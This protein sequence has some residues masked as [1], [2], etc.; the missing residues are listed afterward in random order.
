M[1]ELGWVEGRNTEYVL[2]Y[3]GGDARRYEPVIAELLAQRPDVRY[4]YFRSMALIAKKLTQEVPIVFTISSKPR[5][6]GLV[7]S[8]ARPG[9][10]VTG[11]STRAYELDGKRFELLLEIKPGIQ[12]MTV[13]V[14][15]GL[16]ESDICRMEAP[17]SSGLVAMIH[18][19]PWRKSTDRS[20][21]GIGS[22][23]AL[24]R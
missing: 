22:C 19:L 5:E 24:R 8:L 9:G 17:S 10:N 20:C 4:A 7:A 2:A 6:S 16:P 21:C 13:L 18:S 3:A 11:A 23:L 12:H 14:N 1:I 15:P